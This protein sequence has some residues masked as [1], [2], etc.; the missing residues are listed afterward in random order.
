MDEFRN[1]TSKI[2]IEIRTIAFRNVTFKS[3]ES[4][5]VTSLAE[6]LKFYYNNIT[7]LYL[8]VFWISRF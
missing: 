3:A 7:Y 8:L 4:V 1:S 5:D 2:A 6:T